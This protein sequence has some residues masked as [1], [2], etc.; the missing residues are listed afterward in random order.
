MQPQSR[1][2]IGI[3]QCTFVYEMMNMILIIIITQFD[4]S[5]PDRCFPLCSIKMMDIVRLCSENSRYAD[6]LILSLLSFYSP[7]RRLSRVPLAKKKKKDN[8]R[9]AQLYDLSCNCTL[10][11]PTVGFSLANER[12]RAGR[13]GSEEE[14]EEAAVMN[15]LVKKV[16]AADPDQKWRL[17]LFSSGLKHRQEDVTSAGVSDGVE[18]K[19]QQDD[20]SVGGGEKKKYISDH[21]TGRKSYHSPFLSLPT[22]DLLS[23]SQ[24]FLSVNCRKR[25]KFQ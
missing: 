19:C 23:F 5:S 9:N 14:E 24:W 1:R 20:L 2:R 11:N 25:L 3:F 15:E 7:T 18:A 6:K 8:N 12:R 4:P 17:T 21:N 13:D 10:L 16:R 22:S